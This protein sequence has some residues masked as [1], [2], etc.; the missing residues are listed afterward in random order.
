MFITCGLVASF[1]DKS[2]SIPIGT[3]PL[4]SIC[5]CNPFSIKTTVSSKSSQYGDGQEKT[6]LAFNVP[7]SLL[8]LFSNI[9]N[10]GTA[11]ICLD[12]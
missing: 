10:C 11:L 2:I 4:F 3:S 9:G 7:A 5:F 8:F 6:T 1:I 12:K